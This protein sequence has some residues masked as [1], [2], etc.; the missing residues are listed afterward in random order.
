MACSTFLAAAMRSRR[1]S[2]RSGRAETAVLPAAASGGMAAVFALSGRQTSSRICRRQRAMPIR[3]SARAIGH[4]E[5]VRITYDPR[6]S[7]TAAA[8][9]LLHVAH[10]P[11]SESAGSRRRPSY[12]SAHLPADRRRRRGGAGVHRRVSASGARSAD[13]DAD[14]ARRVLPAEADHQDFARRTRCTPI[15]WSTTGQGR[16]AQACYPSVS[17]AKTLKPLR[18]HALFRQGATKRGHDTY[19]ARRAPSGRGRCG[20]C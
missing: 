14:R 6:R 5:A 3:A 4:A 2:V 8:A 15:S 9:D 12:R 1:S 17:R 10:D 16:R 7:A 11:R 18:F 19:M 13:R 20:P